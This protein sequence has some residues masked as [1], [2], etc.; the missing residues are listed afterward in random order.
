MSQVHHENKFPDCLYMHLEGILVESEQINLPITIEFNEQWESVEGGR[1][2]FGL[3]GGTLNLN[4]KNGYIPQNLC[5]LTGLKMLQ[6]RQATETLQFPSICEVTTNGSESNPAWLFEVK[7]AS[8]VL[9]GTL[10]KENLGT[11][12][13]N[14]QPCCAEATFEVG[15]KHVHI[16]RIEGLWSEQSSINKQRIAQVRVRKNLYSLLQPYMSRVELRY[17]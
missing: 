7:T 13:I 16:T 6:E 9:K 5:N 1:V 10:P 17:G 3:K 14:N 15:L 12:T 4:L 11:V 2:K 8:S